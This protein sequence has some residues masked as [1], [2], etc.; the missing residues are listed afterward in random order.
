MTQ[1]SA[2]AV[3]N[4]RTI[5]VPT[6]EFMTSEVHRLVGELRHAKELR[7]ALI[8]LNRLTKGEL[9]EDVN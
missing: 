6:V 5:T 3:A 7:A 2:P 4:M 9:V 1:A 8:N